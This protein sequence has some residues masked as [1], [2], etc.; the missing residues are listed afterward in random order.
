M[1][2]LA[3]ALLTLAGC[4]TLQQ[5]AMLALSSQQPKLCSKLLAEQLVPFLNHAQSGDDEPWLVGFSPEAVSAALAP[6]HD[7]YEHRYENPR[8]YQTLLSCYT[9]R[10][11]SRLPSLLVTG[12]NASLL[13]RSTSWARSKR[14]TS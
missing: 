13:R 11:A 4:S 5:A 7:G 8:A 1:L 12:W 9:N 3:S 14:S 10:D 2:K 6:A